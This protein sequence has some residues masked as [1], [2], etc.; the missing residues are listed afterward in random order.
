VPQRLS[1][2]Y[3]SV[4][5]GAD[6]G[7]GSSR[8]RRIDPEYKGL[9][10]WYAPSVGNLPIQLA[11]LVCQRASCWWDAKL[12]RR[13]AIWV[14]IALGIFSA[15]IVMLSLKKGA[16]LE[17]FILVGLTPLMPAIIL[18]VKQFYE[19]NDAAA[20]ADRLKEYTEKLWSEALQGGS[21]PE[22]LAVR[23][24]QLQDEIYE[25]R[26]RSPLIFNWI[27]WR[28][29][30]QHEELMNKG[31]DALVSEALRSLGQTSSG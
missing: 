31:A 29:R 9:R 5:Q 3:F 19:H 21:S 27:Y 15:V 10:D 8:H 16:T 24:R 4:L 6:G 28:L 11:R 14:L 17:N 13:Y 1:C 20:R 25:H 18:A 26:R 12:R 7:T 30:N 2:C 23:S 22:E